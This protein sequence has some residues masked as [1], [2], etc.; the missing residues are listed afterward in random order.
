M[1][2]H[3]EKA[4]ALPNILGQEPQQTNEKE[5]KTMVFPKNSALRLG[6]FM[7]LLLALLLASG[8]RTATVNSIA[9]HDSSRWKTEIAT[10][11]VQDATNAPASGCIVFTGSSYI[12]LWKSLAVDFPGLPVVNRGFGG[13]QLADVYHYADRIVIRYAPREVVLYAG[14]NDIHAGKE[15]EVV[16]GDFVAVMTKLRNALPQVRLVFVSCPPSPQRWAETAD[17]R[18]ANALIADY[19]RSHDIAFVNTFE[20]MLGPDGL[21]RPDIYAADRLHMNAKGYAIW[22]DA[23]APHLR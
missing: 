9:T 6:S 1:K 17:I 5:M 2:E 10:Y 7:A 15:P 3:N 18:K 16:Y 12:R 8:C 23:V 11:E 14:G 19:C 4:G 13:C 20:L 22:R 21:P